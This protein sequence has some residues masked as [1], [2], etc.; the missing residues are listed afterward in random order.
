MMK[1]SGRRF[2]WGVNCLLLFAAAMIFRPVRTWIDQVVVARCLHPNLK[3]HELRVHRSSNLRNHTIVQASHFDWGSTDD[4]RCFGITAENAWI[5]IKDEPLLTKSVSIPQA[6]LQNSR[7]YMQSLPPTD[8][9]A[10]LAVGVDNHPVDNV[11]SI[12]QRHLSKKQGNWDWSDLKEYLDSTLQ[13][14]QFA[15]DCTARIEGW[16]ARSKKLAN[17]AEELTDGQSG[18]NNPLRDPDDIERKLIQVEELSEKQDELRLEL[19]SFEQLIEGKLKFIGE[20]YEQQR[21]AWDEDHVHADRDA[22]PDDQPDRLDIDIKSVAIE[23]LERA[24]HRAQTEFGVFMELADRFCRAVTRDPR[25]NY[26]RD[27]RT[28]G[29]ELISVQQ[30]TASGM[31][32][33]DPIMVP[34]RLSTTGMQRQTSGAESFTQASFLYQFDAAPVRLLITAENQRDNQNSNEL[35]M[36]LLPL[37]TAQAQSKEDGK[38]PNSP[39]SPQWRLLSDGSHVSGHLDLDARIIPVLLRDYPAMI[40]S[41]VSTLQDSPVESN[42]VIR[43]NFTGTWNSV[44]W[45]LTDN[46]LPF[47]F[48]KE[49]MLEQQRRMQERSQKQ[50]AH[51]EQYFHGQVESLDTVLQRV[52]DLALEQSQQHSK[53]ILAAQSMLHNELNRARQIEFA[54]QPKEDVKR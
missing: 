40:E 13:T 43:L 19:N 52:L 34:F 6:V 21:A 22:K 44:R 8:R 37:N 41:A 24:G 36:E 53:T 1:I 7:L 30:L 28:T 54:R 39:Q 18:W 31:F 15:S 25:P 32:R 50:I 11:D 48:V 23:L 14:S 20:S 4:A 29:R 46:D 42:A 12:W 47:W 10:S 3:V 26:D 5:V 2:V 49:I 33:C 38:L 27:F 35:L 45:T 17:S 51:V 16:I 9:L